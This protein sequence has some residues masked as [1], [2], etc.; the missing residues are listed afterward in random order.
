M[1]PVVFL[2]IASVLTLIHAVLHT[3]GGVYSSPDPGP[4]TVAVTAMKANE[5]LLMGNVRTY[6]QFYRGMGLSVTILLVVEG[7]VFWLLG[8]VVK[9]DRT[10]LRPVLGMFLVGYLAMSVNSYLHFFWAPVVVEFL[11]ALC[12]VGAMVTAKAP[13]SVG[14]R[15]TA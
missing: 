4:Q 6:F 7:I 3:I 9:T 10:R 1:K 11:I 14:Q 2:R 15:A 12:V 13:A 8:S 5:F